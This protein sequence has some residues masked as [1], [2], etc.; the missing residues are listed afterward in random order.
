MGERGLNL[1]SES[2][3]DEFQISLCS[4]N[5][6]IVVDYRAT[7]TEINKK[8]NYSLINQYSLKVTFGGIFE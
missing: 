3:T 5:N 7:Q 8:L 1:Q 4:V 2:F 6:V